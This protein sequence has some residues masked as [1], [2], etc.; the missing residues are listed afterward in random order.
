MKC[1]TKWLADWLMW[2]AAAAF[3]PC[4]PGV[5]VSV[6]WP[7]GRPFVMDCFYCFGVWER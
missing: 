6:C 7:A 3:R 1:L 4:M 5:G 2:R